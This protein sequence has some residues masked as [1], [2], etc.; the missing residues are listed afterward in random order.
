MQGKRCSCRASLDRAGWQGDDK[1]GAGA[2]GSSCSLSV[3][4]LASLLLNILKA[5][6]RGQLAST[7]VTSFDWA[8]TGSLQLGLFPG[9]GLFP[10][11]GHLQSLIPFPTCSGE[12]SKHHQAFWPAF[13]L[14][15][16]W[17]PSFHLADFKVSKFEV[18]RTWGGW[19]ARS[20]SSL[21]PCYSAAAD[22]MVWRR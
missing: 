22:V 20:K 13:L 18:E 5:L 10:R 11:L 1:Q 9:L 21:F 4:S 7:M 15:S 6:L 19:P 3:S 2:G 16:F 12:R 14:A 17:P 8:S